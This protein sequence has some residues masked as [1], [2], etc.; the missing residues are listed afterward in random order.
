ACGGWAGMDWGRGEHGPEGAR[1]GLRGSTWVGDD[2]QS[3]EVL[4]P[5]ECRDLLDQIHAT[6]SRI[7][8]AFDARKRSMGLAERNRHTYRSR[9][10]LSGVRTGEERRWIDWETRYERRLSRMR[11][12]IQD[13]RK[14]TYLRAVRDLR[15]R[16]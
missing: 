15:S 1:D 10:M 4:L 12:R 5:G 2:G 7:D 6:Q 11:D 13:L 8:R 14:E 3:G 16:Y 9:L